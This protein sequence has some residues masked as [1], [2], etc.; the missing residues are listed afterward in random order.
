MVDL[1]KNVGSERLTSK[2]TK[3][4]IRKQA[5][6]FWV[7]FV[8]SVLIYFN[9]NWDYVLIPDTCFP[10]EIDKLISNGF[11]VVHIRVV[12]P[13][14]KSPLTE[15]QQK[16]TSEVALDNIKP[17][18]YIYNEGSMEEL[19]EFSI[20]RLIYNLTIVLTIVYR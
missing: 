7:D 11:D 5:P 8:S 13:N 2:K 3:R 17:D 14:F 10:N 6:D 15:E 12:R 4:F 18:F 20:K 9:E 19:Q 16:H 1:T